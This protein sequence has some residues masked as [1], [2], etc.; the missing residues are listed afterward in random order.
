ML[1]FPIFS[2]VGQFARHILS[3]GKQAQ[4]ASFQQRIRQREQLGQRRQAPAP[5][6]R[7][8]DSGALSTKSSILTRVDDGGSARHLHGL[9]QKRRLL[10]DAL[11]QVDLRTFGVRKC[12]GD[13]DPGKAGAG[14]EVE[15]RLWR[16]GPNRRS[17]S[18]LATCRV[19]ITG[20]GRA[21][22][23]VGVFLPSDKSSTKRSSRADVSR[24]TGVSGQGTFAVGGKVERF[25]RSRFLADRA[26][27]AP[28]SRLRRSRW[29]WA[30]SS[31]SAAGVIPSSRLA[32][33]MVRGLWVCSLWRTS[34]DSPGRVS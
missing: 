3:L 22:D 19:Q 13:D 24:E 34:L 8:C 2:G 7:R 12:A 27:A 17:C 33:P 28:R 26:H 31:V 15:P 20:I 10:A 32:C 1:N 29:T 18:E 5:S 16:G 21:R 4:S 25:A 11:D 23:Q 9:A 30:A 6:Q 14:S